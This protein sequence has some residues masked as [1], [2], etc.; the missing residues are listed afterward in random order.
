MREIRRREC[1][2]IFDFG[3]PKRKHPN[4]FF[5]ALSLPKGPHQCESVQISGEV[6]FYPPTPAFY[7]SIIF[8]IGLFQVLLTFS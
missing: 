8:T 1:C 3:T 7:F 6:P 4:I 5:P 2:G